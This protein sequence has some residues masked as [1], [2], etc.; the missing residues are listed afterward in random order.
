MKI[1]VLGG[2]YFIGRHIV[3]ALLPAGEVFVLN[4]GTTSFLPSGARHIAADRQSQAGLDQLEEQRFDVIVDVSAVSPAFVNNTLPYLKAS[5]GAKYIY[6]SSAAV[7]RKTANGK[8]PFTETDPI[9]GDPI[10]GQYGA[11]KSDCEL[12]LAD[13]GFQTYILR[14]PYI[15]GPWNN[16]EREGFLWAQMMKGQTIRVP[17]HSDR[18][19]QFL[20]ASD[21]AKIV[22]L[23]ASQDD[24]PQGIYNVGEPEF[25]TF[26]QYIEILEGIYGKPAI[27]LQMKADIPAREYFPFR[28]ATLALATDRQAQ[29]FGEV[30][31]LR[32]GLEETFRWFATQ[33]Q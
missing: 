19:V 10:W 33:K 25:Y 12:A 6:I 32:A 31:S 14:P 30:R 2:S 4:R 17:P 29:Y 27:T 26:R 3:E 21:L 13:A 18:V 28:D 20:G 8:P 1:L 15:Y 23:I 24:I 16:C 11:D 5:Q 22:G 9:G 7:Y